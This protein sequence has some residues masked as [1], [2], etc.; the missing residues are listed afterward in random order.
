[1]L[2]CESPQLR[3]IEKDTATAPG[4]AARRARFAHRFLEQAALCEASGR[5]RVEELVGVE[6]LDL[7]A[8]GLLDLRRLRSLRQGLFLAIRMG[9][10]GL[11][12][13]RSG[14]LSVH[15]I[16]VSGQ[17]FPSGLTWG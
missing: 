1:G 5:L 6:L 9:S 12:Y 15:R 4:L 8:F 17:W 3:L 2:G 7:L 11:A 14:A 10:W 13:V 16:I